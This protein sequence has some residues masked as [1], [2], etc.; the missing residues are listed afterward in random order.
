MESPGSQQSR[1]NI[2]SWLCSKPLW[3]WWVR[4]FLDPSIQDLMF[5]ADL[6]PWGHRGCAKV[7]QY[8]YQ[9]PMMWVWMDSPWSTYSRFFLLT[10]DPED[11]EGRGCAEILL[12]FLLKTSTIWAS[13]YRLPLTQAFEIWHFGLTWDLQDIEGVWRFICFLFQTAT[14][15]V[16]MDSPWSQH[17]KY[18]ILS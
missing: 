11:S 5:W 12:Y 9:T 10:W 7:H 1:L 15:R 14:I 13:V 6:Q 3:Y 2:L 16:S 17:S 18:D 4:T 8:S